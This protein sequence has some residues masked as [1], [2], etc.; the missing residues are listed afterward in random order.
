LFF[1]I[2]ILNAAVAQAGKP[3]VC[4]R[5]D[6]DFAAI[7]QRAEAND[8]VAQMALASCYD[9]GQHVQPDGKES[10]RWLTESANRGYEPAQYE[11][12]R[13]YLYGRGVPDDYAKAM[14]WERKAAEQGDPRAQRDLALMYE[15]GFGVDADP[16]QAAEWNRKAAVQGHPD[17]QTHLARALDEGAGVSKNPGEAREWYGKAAR[18]EQPA[19]QLALAR[20][21]AQAPDCVQATHWYKDVAVHGESVAMYEL[22]MLYL[23]S[24]CGADRNQAFIW[25]TLGAR[26]G[27]PEGKTEAAR[28]AR[29]LTP[30]QKKRDLLTVERWLKEHPDAGKDENEEEKEER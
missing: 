6:Q 3:D 2:A 26:F 20:K 22:G 19:A 27:S 18:Q 15:R 23:D 21:F 16:A 17:A 5:A 12:G 24:R 1:V 8:P 4:P 30:T 28:L 29:A 25:L 10:I 14:L 7:Q 9:L 11:L 13:I